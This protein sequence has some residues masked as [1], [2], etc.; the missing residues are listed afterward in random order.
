MIAPQDFAAVCSGAAVGFSL[1]VIGG[2]GSILAVPLLLYVVGVADPH[3]AVGTSALAVSIS[4]FVNLIGHARARTVHWPSAAVFATAGLIGATAGS[5]LGK[6][7]DGAKLLVFFAVVMIAAAVAMVRPRSAGSACPPPLDRRNAMRLAGFGTGA[8][9]ASGFFG[10]GG[11][12]MI[13]PGIVLATGMPILNA[14]GTSLFSVAIFALTTAVNYAVSGFVA[15][16]IAAE[17]IAGGAVGG[18]AGTLAAVR[19][20]QRK[21]LLS[22]VFAGV[23]FIVAIYMLVTTVTGLHQIA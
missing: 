8:G 9:F 15:W 3:I 5:S 6:S 22:Y 23:V 14:I 12:F 10:I 19:L 17:F 4:A 21:R 11:G 18:V 20:A 16:T 2:G 13:V 1:G 7:V